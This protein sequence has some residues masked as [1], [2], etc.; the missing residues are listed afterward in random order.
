MALK[1][2]ISP[3]YSCYTANVLL[4]ELQA[5]RSHVL[6]T[7]LSLQDYLLGLYTSKNRQCRLGYDSSPQCDS[8]QL[9]EFVKYLTRIGTL[10]LHGTYTESEEP[11]IASGDIRTMMRDLRACPSYQLDPNHAHCGPKKQLLAG[12]DFIQARIAETHIGICYRCWRTPTKVHSWSKLKRLPFFNTKNETYVSSNDPGAC[13]RARVHD[14]A[15]DFFM[16]VDRGWQPLL[17]GRS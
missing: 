4:E 14:S 10:R 11:P 2:R 16:A 6:E 12:L 17:Y 7:I 13:D 15:A 9:G 3:Q 1:V 5:R 8:F